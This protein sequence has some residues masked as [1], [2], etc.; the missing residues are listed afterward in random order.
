[1][2]GET[3]SG[4]LINISAPVLLGGIGLMIGAVIGACLPPGE[5]WTEVPL[6][7]IKFGFTPARDN[8]F[9]LEVSLNF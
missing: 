7:T 4:G 1:M 2:Y 8:G 6:R 9:A 5:S 3:G